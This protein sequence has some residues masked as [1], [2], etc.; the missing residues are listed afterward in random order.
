MIITYHTMSFPMSID[1]RGI[2][3]MMKIYP[4]MIDYIETLETFWISE[5]FEMNDRDEDESAVSTLCVINSD[6]I[7]AVV[8]NDFGGEYLVDLRT[9]DSFLS[10]CSDRQ[11]CKL[12]SPDLEAPG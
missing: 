4:P 5:L 3:N 6:D 11:F 1:V 9:K 12:G 2:A 7:F 8:E 10:T